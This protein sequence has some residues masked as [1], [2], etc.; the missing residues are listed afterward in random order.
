[1]DCH[2]RSIS[3][4]ICLGSSEDIKRQLPSATRHGHVQHLSRPSMSE[5]ARLSLQITGE[6]HLLTMLIA[7]HRGYRENSPCLHT[8][9]EAIGAPLIT[10][11]YLHIEGHQRATNLSPHPLVSRGP[12]MLLPELPSCLQNMGT[13]AE[14][15]YS[16]ASIM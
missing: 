5:H 14:A 8:I 4:K 7:W 11:S 6:Q 15:T 9:E 10:T 12:I 1:M 13:S 2:L 3:S 16:K